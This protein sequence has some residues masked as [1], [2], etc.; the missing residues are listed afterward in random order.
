[1]NQHSDHSTGG[2]FHCGLSIPPGTRYHTRLDDVERD[3]CCVG[4]QSVCSAIF[5]AGLQGYYQRTPE[6]V[7]L[8][9]PPEPPKDIEIYDL[10]EVQQEFIT[11]SGDLRDIHLLVEGIHCPA[12]VWSVSYTH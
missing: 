6:G 3:F 12:C 9:P 8:A 2:C 11:C 7:L 4:C 1:M 10:D 5:E